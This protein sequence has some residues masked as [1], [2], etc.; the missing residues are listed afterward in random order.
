MLAH[1]SCLVVEKRARS[2]SRRRAMEREHVERTR[3]H[4]PLRRARE[5][6][7][8]LLALAQRPVAQ[9][10]RDSGCDLGIGGETIQKALPERLVAEL[11]H[12]ETGRHRG[13]LLAAL[14][15]REREIGGM[16]LP[17]DEA[18][19]VVGRAALDL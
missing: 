6:A 15:C 3:A 8:E 18:G 13:A 2:R 16:P 1:G 10:T 14:E 5:P 12:Y 19:Q 4:D 11:E 9:R 17:H 7:Q